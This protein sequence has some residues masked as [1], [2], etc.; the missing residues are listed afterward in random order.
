MIT[1]LEGQNRAT[2]GIRRVDRAPSAAVAGALFAL[3][4]AFSATSTA[5][6]PCIDTA[7]A[8]S[9]EEQRLSAK[10][11]TGNANAFSVDL[12]VGTGFDHFGP[13]FIAA[14]CNT[15]GPPPT[16]RHSLSCRRKVGC[17]GVPPSIASR[18]AR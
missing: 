5:Q 12:L 17:Y 18:G 16:I 6:A 15:G 11:T 2:A 10:L 4:L 7:V 9:A 3:S 13:D 1:G 14:L 8:P